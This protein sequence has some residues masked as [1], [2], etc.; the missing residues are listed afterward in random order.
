VVL[1]K[2]IMKLQVYILISLTIKVGI[3]PTNYFGMHV[4]F[5]NLNNIL[6]SFLDVRCIVFYKKIQNIRCM[7]KLWDFF[8][9]NLEVDLIWRDKISRFL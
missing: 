1:L 7:A 9:H 6:S 8:L 5:S 4:T 3:L 2:E